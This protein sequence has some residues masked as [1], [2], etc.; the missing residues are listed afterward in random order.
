[1]GGVGLMIGGGRGWGVA[2]AK[3]KAEEVVT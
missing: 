2:A 3:E 1:V